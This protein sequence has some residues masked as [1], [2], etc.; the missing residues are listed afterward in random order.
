MKSVSDKSDQQV[1]DEFLA[2]DG[3][4]GQAL[5][6]VLKAAL[7][8]AS[9][10]KDAEIA[11]LKAIIETQSA[12]FWNLV[13]VRRALEQRVAEVEHELKVANMPEKSLDVPEGST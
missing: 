10:A 12:E 7:A 8:V 9:P 2:P 1:V 5:A 11:R 3:P 4:A 13:Q 6:R